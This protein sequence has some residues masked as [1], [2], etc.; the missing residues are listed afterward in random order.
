MSSDRRL[1]RQA[2]FTLIELMVVVTLTAIL[3]I[4][5][6][7]FGIHWTRNASVTRAQATLQ[8]AY[9]VAK[10]LALANPGQ[11]VS[12]AGAA[13]VCFA[14]AGITVYS[15]SKCSGNLVWAG[16]LPT[17]V[18]LS[19][20]GATTGCLALSDAALPVAGASGCTAS[21]TYSISRG[22]VSVTGK[23]LY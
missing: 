7:A 6:A 5:S 17:G 9:S 10:S 23:A 4:L 13:T 18:S 3:L 14:P 1:A 15:G 20:G 22:D 11:Q 8:Q 21:R 16:T 12:G 19:V 2:G